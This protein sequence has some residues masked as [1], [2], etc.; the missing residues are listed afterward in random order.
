VKGLALRTV[1]YL[2]LDILLLCVSILNVPYLK[3][4]PRM[5]FA[6]SERQGGVFVDRLTDQAAAGEIRTGDLL[7]RIGNEPVLSDHLTEFLS[8]FAST[9]DS[10]SLEVRREG[11]VRPVQARL[12][13]CYAVGYTLVT[14]FVGIV[15]WIVGVVVLLLRPRDRTAAVLHWAL[16]SLGLAVMLMLGRTPP[17]DSFP[18]ISRSVF[19]AMYMNL[20]ASFLLF[21]T[22]FPRPKQGSFPL[23][24][25]VVYLPAIVVAAAVIIVHRQAVQTA[26]AADYETFKTLYDVFHVVLLVYVVLGILN[27][28]HS[29]R[30]TQDVEERKKLKWILWGL[31]IGPAPFL[32]LETVPEFFVAI[33]PVPEEYTL[34]F[35]VLIPLS[36]AISFVRYHILDIEIVINRTTVYGVVIGLLVLVYLVIVG[37]V[38]LLAG[39]YSQGAYAFGAVLVALLFEPARARVQRFVDRRFFRVRYDYRVAERR[40]S[41]KI[42]HCPSQQKLASVLV[43][44]TDALIPLRR[45]GFF[46]LSESGK[47]V[48]CIAHRGFEQL[49]R[50]SVGLQAGE[51]RNRLELP[52]A[53]PERIEAGVAHER[54]D[55]TVF[56]RWEIEVVFPILSAS[57]MVL[58]FLVLGQK[59]SGA[60]FTIEDIDLLSNVANQAG[61]E[62]E[63]ITLQQ[64]LVR[65]QAEAEQ[66][67][68]L[69]QLK[70]DF[71]SYVSHELRTP[72]TSI[73]LYAELLEGRTRSLDRKGRS[74]IRVILGEAERLDRMVSTV[75][76]SAKIEQGVK[77]YRFAPADLRQIT[78]QVLQ[79]IE[80]Q[81]RKHHF[82]VVYVPH[83]REIPFL[84][85][86][87]AVGQAITNI[88]GNA[89]KYSADRKYL[90]VEIRRRGEWAVCT[91]TDHGVGIAMDALPHIFEKFYRDPARSAE[92]QG[93]GLGLPLV[94]HIVDAHGGQI[95]VRST[96]GRGST[97][98]LRFPLA[99]PSDAAQEADRTGGG[100]LK[101]S[102]A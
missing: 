22:L 72:L 88:I 26:S 65:K 84:S 30:T 2:V 98:T 14:L 5:P 82:K 6:C 68:E 93:V 75:L 101:G 50:H 66:L 33:S 56:R 89:I 48:R 70:S 96:V 78:E 45:V 85:D 43:E 83:T 13:P 3:E 86:A 1:L 67:A 102:Q 18:L 61:V 90:K 10:V 37:V 27:F 38:A 92:T 32:L 76:D 31:S 25:L 15:A 9:G 54:A 62:I 20:A 100:H 57:R 21:T 77:Q 12:V 16:V 44:E 17:G 95:D 51:R 74:H 11:V 63:R 53:L 60:R 55:A 87:D 7:L 80:Y 73:K 46:E 64:K 71:V 40:F 69:N 19:F 49:G 52:V 39:S 99:G 58:G 81:L 29:Y 91:I 42:T 8:D 34:V 97:F 28:V 24:L 23:K 4:R 59:K 35:L 36:F 47:S 41:E 79:A 94:K